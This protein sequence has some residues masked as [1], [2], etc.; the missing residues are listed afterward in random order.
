M[1]IMKKLSNGAAPVSRR[2][3]VRIGAALG[4]G[5]LVSVYATGCAPKGDETAAASKGGAG[6]AGDRKVPRPRPGP[7][8]E[9]RGRRA[10]GRSAGVAGRAGDRCGSW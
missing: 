9:G 8:R 1:A 2:D 7:R 5:L 3:F 4:G 10:A 6:G